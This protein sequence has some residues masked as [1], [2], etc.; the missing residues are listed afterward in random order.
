MNNLGVVEINGTNVQLFAGEQAE[1][2]VPITIVA[3]TGVVPVGQVLGRVTASGKYAK[4]VD[5]NSNGT[6]VARLI[7]AEA[8]DATAA[9]VN[10]SAMY[11]GVFNRAALTGI[12]QAG[13]YDL[14][15]RGILVKA[16]G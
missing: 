9:D 3:G 6:E 13:E 8:V 2:F 4:Y 15:D 1:D 5:G 11:N 12:D 14:L 10:T 7:A 16:L